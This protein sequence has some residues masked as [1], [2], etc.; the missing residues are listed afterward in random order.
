MV[1]EGRPQG[2]VAEELRKPVE[3]GTLILGVG[4]VV[5]GVVAKHQPDIG[6]VPIVVAEGIVNAGGSP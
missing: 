1:A 5:V 2:G 4:A 6:V 3:D